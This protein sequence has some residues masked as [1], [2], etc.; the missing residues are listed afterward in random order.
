M[1]T[2]VVGIFGVGILVRGGGVRGDRR[3][4]RGDRSTGAGGTGNH[5]DR[6]GG[7][8]GDP[9]VTMVLVT[10][11]GGDRRVPRVVPVV[12]QPWCGNRGRGDH[13]RGSSAHG[14]EHVTAP[15][16]Q[17]SRQH[18]LTNQLSPS[19]HSSV[20]ATFLETSGRFPKGSV[21]RVDVSSQSTL[22]GECVV[23]LGLLGVFDKCA[24]LNRQ[25]S[26]D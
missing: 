17:S 20:A 22:D 1:V 5:S 2:V 3:G 11:S 12:W 25:R 19:D 26:T 16:P 7:A 4:N 23:V 15:P 9:C 6:G 8:S 18:R 21:Q 14:G 13:R 24:C 10:K